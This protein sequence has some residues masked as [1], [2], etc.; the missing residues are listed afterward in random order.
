MTKIE[1]FDFEYIQKNTELKYFHGKT[2]LISGANGF[3]ASNF[4]KFLLYLNEN[5]LEQNKVKIIAIARNEKKCKEKFFQHLNTKEIKFIFQDINA[6]LKFKEK[7]DYIIHAASQASPIFYGVDPVGTMNSN[8]I[9]TISLLE[10][11]KEKKVESFLFLSSSEIYGKDFNTVNEMIVE[12]EVGKIDL[13]DIRNC[14]AESKHVGEFYTKAYW[15]QYAVP[16]K[17]ARI[18]HTYGPGL[19]LGDGRVFM[20]FIEDIIFERDIMMKSSGSAKRCFCYISDAL[21][22]FF[23]ILFLGENGESYNVGNMSQEISILE[24]AEK[25]VKLFPEKNLKVI[26]QNRMENDKYIPS[27]VNRALPCIEKMR[28]L[29]WDPKISIDEGFN[30]TILYFQEKMNW[31]N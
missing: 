10:L 26:V 25:L 3:I 23:K 15:K 31:K 13:E 28:K 20:D 6:P 8:I 27:K 1:G 16:A 11:A 2:F 5:V 18:F 22:A 29:N 14:Y 9:G 24:L 7:I 30:R 17:S 12:E 21:I 19:S 4:I